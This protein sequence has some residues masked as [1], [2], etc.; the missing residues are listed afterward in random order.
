MDKSVYNDI[1]KELNL[2]PEVVKEA[3]LTQWKFIKMKIEEPPLS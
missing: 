1:A 3:Y 2:D